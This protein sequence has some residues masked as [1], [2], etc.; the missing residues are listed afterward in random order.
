MDCPEASG[1]LV[2][3]QLL[4]LARVCVNLQVAEKFSRLRCSAGV[5]VVTGAE[6]RPRHW[7]PVC[8]RVKYVK[9]PRSVI[10]REGRLAW[11][12][13]PATPSA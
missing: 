4:E 1:H 9:E 8:G 3:E 7:S 2:I 13:G 6:F 10:I 11:P 12:D 5:S